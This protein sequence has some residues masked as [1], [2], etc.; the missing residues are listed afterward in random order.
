MSLL[1]LRVEKRVELDT[2][3]PSGKTLREV[4]T[5][6]RDAYGYEDPRLTSEPELPMFVMELWNAFWKMD[7]RRDR[8]MYGSPLP[9][10]YEQIDAYMRVKSHPLMPWEIEAIE[11][12]D[13]ALLRAQAENKNNG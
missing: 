10:R 4:L 9:L 1:V 12:M 11:A 8:G 5:A 13:L 7:F 3:L 2:P 6:T